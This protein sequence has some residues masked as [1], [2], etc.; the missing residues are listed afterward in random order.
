[1]LGGGG[2]VLE[3]CIFVNAFRAE[4]QAKFFTEEAVAGLSGVPEMFNT[5]GEE[6]PSTLL[7]M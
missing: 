5:A 3:P 2:G 4:A 1:M 6:E 7:G